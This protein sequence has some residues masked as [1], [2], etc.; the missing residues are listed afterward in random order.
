V[1]SVKLVA[2]PDA[3][4]VEVPLE[5]EAELPRDF[6]GAALLASSGLPR[7]VR[8][9]ATKDS[10][11]LSTAYRADQLLGDIVR[12]AL[13]G[14]ANDIIRV[15]DAVMKFIR[16]VRERRQDGATLLVSSNGRGKI[17]VVESGVTARLAPVQAAPEPGGPPSPPAPDRLAALERRVGDLEAAVRRTAQAAD[18]A[19]RVAQLEQRIPT[20]PIARA[21]R[22]LQEPADPA[23]E[24]SF[25]PPRRATA[26]EAYADGLRMDLRGRAAADAAKAR[27]EMERGDKAA[28]LAA[29]AELLGAPQDG[30]AQRLRDSAAQAA[31]RQSGLTRLAEEI[32]FYGSG[33]LPVAAQLLAKLEDSRSSD[34]APILEVIA[35]A[36]A[37]AAKRGG[38]D[39]RVSWLQRAAALCAWQLVEPQPGESLDSGFE[40]VDSGGTSV[41]AV[42]CPGVK[43]ADGAVIVRPRVLGVAKPP[44]KTPASGESLAASE[45]DLA[46]K[47][48]A[49]ITAEAASS[50]GLPITAEAASSAGAAIEALAPPAEP[51]ASLPASE[52]T[53]AALPLVERTTPFALLPAPNASVLSLLD[54][55]AETAIGLEEAA[56]AAAAAARVPRVVADDAQVRD[57]ALAAVG[58]EPA[59]YELDD[60]DVE[61]IHQLVYPV[62][63]ES[64][65][66]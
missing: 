7:R 34:P 62:P 66:G 53:P 47:P 1:F 55:S 26:I 17:D 8:I 5:I 61:E 23:P 21:A 14:A 31:A 38:R 46:P 36:V 63:T 16:A 27:A 22:S 58:T 48:E 40:V 41:A 44:E 49:L 10:L 51:P 64:K 15:Q 57:E 32:E 13:R 4:M 54:L 6:E 20:A 43:R 24:R 37:S 9:K 29:D 19:D 45:A 50:S 42:V 18:L 25:T 11:K 52:P 60:S 30:T 39:G 28:A 33:D 2:R 3:R 59:H 65:P 35:Q 56:A 12:S